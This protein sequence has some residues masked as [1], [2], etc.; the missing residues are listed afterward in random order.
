MPDDVK[1]T[2]RDGLRA[3]EEQFADNERAFADYSDDD[4]RDFRSRML[5]ARTWLAHV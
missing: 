2:L 1:D 3:L 5:K 4:K